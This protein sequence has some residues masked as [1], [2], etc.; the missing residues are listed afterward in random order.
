MFQKNLIKIAFSICVVSLATACAFKTTQQPLEVQ[1]ATHSTRF[2]I[3]KMNLSAHE[4][5]IATGDNHV[6]HVQFDGEVQNGE[7]FVQCVHHVEVTD[8]NGKPVS[9]YV[10]DREDY[11][12]VVNVLEGV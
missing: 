5:V 8:L 3:Q 9:D 1:S 11:E 7:L 12:Q 6:L 4:A 10:L 2:S